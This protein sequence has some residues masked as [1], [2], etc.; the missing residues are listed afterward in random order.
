MEKEQASYW[1][2]PSD[3]DENSIVMTDIY[4]DDI[5]YTEVSQLSAFTF[6]ALV[7]N[8]GGALGLWTGASVIT[9]IHA[10]YFCCFLSFPKPEVEESN[11]RRSISQDNW[12]VSQD[13]GQNLSYR[14]TSLLPKQNVET[15]L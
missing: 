6:E 5:L 1:R 4:F 2:L 14:R 7:S 12:C 15:L 13:R 3:C 11:W 9:L 10:I 8:I